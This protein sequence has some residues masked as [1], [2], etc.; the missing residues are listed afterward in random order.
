MCAAMLILAR[1]CLARS[2]IP[3]TLSGFAHSRSAIWAR[4]SP[5]SCSFQRPISFGGRAPFRNAVHPTLASSSLRAAILAT[6]PQGAKL[7]S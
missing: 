7:V 5:C 3:L 4:V 2:I 1:R 6:S